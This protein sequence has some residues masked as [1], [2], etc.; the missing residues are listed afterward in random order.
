MK[1]ELNDDLKIYYDL[2]LFKDKL[3][4]IIDTSD[5]KTK[6]INALK[7]K[8]NGNKEIESQNVN[9][10][11]LNFEYNVKEIEELSD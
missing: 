11:E 4:N 2:S 7:I 8:V 10:S 3:A 9:S 6:G 1:K 5:K